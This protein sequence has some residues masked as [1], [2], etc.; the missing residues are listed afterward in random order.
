M[1]VCTLLQVDN[2]ASTPPLSFFTGRCPSCR[3]TNRVKAL[4]AMPL[5]PSSIIRYRSRAVMPCGLEGNCG[6][7]VALAMRHRLQWFIHLQAHGLDR[8]MSTPPTLSCGVWPIYLSAIL[9]N[10]HW[11]TYI[12]DLFLCLAKAHSHVCC[13]CTQLDVVD[14]LIRLLVKER[15]HSAGLMLFVAHSQTLSC[16]FIIVTFT[17]DIFNFVPLALY[18]WTAWQLQSCGFS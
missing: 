8:E 15:P 16:R 18:R 2:H 1:H 6:S 11:V 13:W 5:S 4:K 3:P 17:S 7:V 9:Y 10:T 14:L 12:L